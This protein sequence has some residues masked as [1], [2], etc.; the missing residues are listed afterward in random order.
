MAPASERGR[1]PARAFALLALAAL[2]LRVGTNLSRVDENYAEG[3]YRGT[4]AKA[5][6]DG[7]PTWPSHWPEIPHVRGSV[8]IS[9]LAAPFYWAM[10][11]TT[12]A[13]R[14]SGIVFH[15]AGLFAWMLL[16][17]RRLG[18]KASILAGAL[19]VFAPPGLAKMAV[20]SYGDHVESLPF[21]LTAALLTLAWLEAES[22]RR[23]LA[24]AAASGLT[25]GLSI[26]FHA[27]AMLGIAGLAAVSALLAPAAALRR[28][29]WLGF[30][31][32]L[33]VGFLPLLAGNAITHTNALLLFGKNPTE[34]LASGAF[35]ARAAKWWNLWVNDF[36]T[37]FQLPSRLLADAVLLLAAGCAGALA[38]A[39][40]RRRRRGETTMRA[41]LADVGFFVA[42]P[43]VFSAAFASSPF[44]LEDTRSNALEVRYVLPV[45]PF[46][47]LPIAVAAA[48]LWERGRRGA[49]IA[50][51]S[52]AL[53]LGVYGS[54]STWSLP[55][56][57]REPA[58]LGYLWEEFDHHLAY[59]SLDERA[60]AEVD[61]AEARLAGDPKRADATLELLAANLD[62]AKMLALVRR[63][64]PWEEWTYPLRWIPPRLPLPAIPD[65]PAP[66][67][68]WL[69][70]TPEPAR[71]F[72]AAAAGDLVAASDPYRADL[73][74][75][76]LYSVRTADER[77]AFAR[78]F[79]H[80]LLEVAKWR[81]VRFFDAPAAWRRSAELPAEV[82]RADVAFGLGFRIGKFV[83]EFYP[84]GDEL[85]GKVFA[86]FP[87]PHHAA[88]AR[89]LGAGYRLR[90]LHPPRADA[91]TPAVERLL[92]LIPAAN[93]ADFRAGLGGAP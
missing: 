19:F 90:F 93:E 65:A 6:V 26:G 50:V 8:A 81:R 28:D 76:A 49:A 75:P 58:R 52:P 24:L 30:V 11:P 41:W 20:L 62:P 29:F 77:R 91:K 48:R 36:S 40:R 22:A 39:W 5:I 83:T 84:Q 16:V 38:V 42:Y 53:A 32:G 86:H 74:E 72:A 71:V 64:D 15:L 45:L 34:H 46:L 1:F 70:S 7:A 12:F 10:G 14:M 13:L 9:V 21:F 4:L 68:R 92:R 31:P 2:I 78:G 33:A 82:D 54:L 51:A 66:L 85:L 60:R 37:S 43:L 35:A 89:G 67:A 73:L 87:R 44:V 18:A 79:G 25:V 17:Q 80:G 88:F 56:M 47:L 3:L 23:R 63:Y 55:T 57:L 69:R 61:A 27:Q 59:G